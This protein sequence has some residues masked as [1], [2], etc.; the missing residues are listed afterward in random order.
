MFFLQ[1]FYGLYTF[2]DFL[3]TL[4]G[5]HPKTKEIVMFCLRLFCRL[6]A[7]FLRTPDFAGCLLG[8]GRRATGD[9]QAAGDGRRAT[10]DGR[11]ATG[12]RRQASGGRQATDD[13]RGPTGRR[14][15]AAGDG[16]QA[17]GDGSMPLP[18]TPPE[19]AESKAQA[20]KASR[21]SC[22]TAHREPAES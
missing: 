7:D 4:C 12:D 6:F 11:R 19:Q 9:G 3:R 22:R 16:R 10:G 14:R 13:G 18:F 5:R 2:T 17:T 20:A 15:E 1:T 8:D 21:A